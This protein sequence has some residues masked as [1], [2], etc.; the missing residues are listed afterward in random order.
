MREYLCGDALKPGRFVVLLGV[1][2][3][4]GLTSKPCEGGY[5]I[6]VELGMSVG[7][8]AIIAALSIQIAAL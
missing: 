5:R 8:A 1:F 7:L 4:G 6:R 2:N 3:P